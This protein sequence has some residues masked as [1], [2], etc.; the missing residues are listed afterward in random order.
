I[1]QVF[2]STSHYTLDM[3]NQLKAFPS[4][5]V[6]QLNVLFPTTQH[7]FPNCEHAD[8]VPTIVDGHE[9]FDIEHI[10]D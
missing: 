2:P 7:L 10:L 4:F 1:I 6:D 9:E 8:L 5:Y 3:P